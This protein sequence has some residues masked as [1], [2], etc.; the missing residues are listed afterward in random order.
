MPHD[1]DQ[2]LGDEATLQ[3]GKPAPAD[4]RSLGDRSTFGGSDGS[5]LSDLGEFA[6]LPD[7]DMEIVDLSSRYKIEKTL[8]KGG[9]GE[10]LL[11]TDTRL[12]RKVAIKRIRG[13]AGSSKAPVARFLTEAKSIAALSHNNVVQ[14]Y[15][16]GRDQDGPFLIM[17]YVSGGSLLDR[18]KQGPI[19]I[20]EAVKM[21]CQLCD[22]L[23]RAHEAG[24]IHRDIKPANILLTVDGVPKL[25]DFGLAKADSQD[26]TMTMAGAVLG[27]LDFMPPEQRQD[28]ALVDTRSDQWS[29]AATLYQMVTG[30]SPKIIRFNDV[31]ETLQ[32]VLG[33]ALEDTKDDRYQSVIDLRDALTQA[34]EIKANETAELH[35][36][37]CPHCGTKNDAT[38][39]FCRNANCGGSLEVP[40]LRCNVKIP[41]WEEVCGSCGAKQEPLI[42][43]RKNQMASMKSDAERHVEIYEFDQARRVCT[44]LEA[45]KDLRLQHLS[46]WIS[47]FTERLQT[48]E[49]RTL[50]LA[51]KR[52][53]EAKQHELAFDYPAAIKTLTRIP[54]SLQNRKLKNQSDTA[55]TY[56]AQLRRKEQQIATLESTLRE[57]IKTQQLTGMLVDVEA[58]LKLVPNHD[59]ALKIKQQLHA[60]E[61]KL[62]T[63]RDQLYEEAVRNFE[64]QN[65]EKTLAALAR[66]D[67][68]QADSAVNQLRDETNTIIRTLKSLNKQIKEKLDAKEYTELEDFVDHFLILKPDDTEKQRLKKQ[69][70]EREDVRKRNKNEGFSEAKKQFQQNDYEAALTSLGKIPRALADHEVRELRDQ[71]KDA[72]EKTT[73]LKREIEK[74]KE[75]PGATTL[76]SRLEEYLK[77]Q[78]DDEA[79]RQLLVQITEEYQR[80]QELAASALSRAHTHAH[81]FQFADALSELAAIPQE[82]RTD[83]ITVL[84]AACRRLQ[85][86]REKALYELQ[87][88]LRFHTYEKALEVTQ[89]Y[90]AASE[91]S[92]TFTEK[93]TEIENLLTE[94]LESQQSHEKESQRLAQRQATKKKTLIITGA[95]ASI[96]LVAG[97]ILWSLNKRSQQSDLLAAAIANR[98]FQQILALDPENKKGLELKKSALIQRALDNGDYATA[99]TLDP[100]NKEALSMETSSK[101]QKAL[102]EGNFATALELD[103]DSVEALSM[104]KVV[105]A[106][107]RRDY[108]TALQVEPANVEALSMKRKADIRAALARQDYDAALKLDPT[109]PEG[110]AMKK[111][112]NISQAISDGDFE[113]AL[114][115]DPDNA[116][117]LEMKSS[118]TLQ[119]A[120]ADG[121]YKT[122]LQIAPTNYQALKMKKVAEI[123]GALA[124]K[125][126]ALALK[127]DPSDAIENIP[128][129]S[130]LSLPVFYNS[131]EMQLRWIPSGNF[132]MGPKSL[133]EPTS[134]RGIEISKPFMIGVY[135]VTQL[136]YEMVMGGK[137]RDPE[138][139]QM[140]AAA[141]WAEA[142]EFC[143]KLSDLPAERAA[144]RVY[145][146]PTEAEWE[147]ACR[148]GTKMPYS[149]G[150]SAFNEATYMND[151]AWW[152][153]N[154]GGHPH[155]VG[156]KRPNPWG[157]Y[158]MH[159]NVWEWCSDWYGD[160]SKSELKDPLGTPLGKLRIMRG[161]SCN[162]KH[163]Q[164]KSAYRFAGEPLRR[165]KIIGFRVALSRS[166]N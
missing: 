15:D 73:Q 66:I 142:V 41:M 131:I 140:P 103:P 156:G 44:Q 94:C 26:H 97:G 57:R 21:A 93:D 20:D 30:K 105:L 58:L 109:N 92:G 119:Q 28:A 101:V 113:A 133:T 49:A 36:G 114:A 82:H 27:T 18:C 138:Y 135:E 96:V 132:A 7:H 34:I 69:L 88:S 83:D 141:T 124:E 134:Q 59:N 47:E 56:L 72:I 70:A 136:Q 71:I 68:T 75:T 146:L 50:E 154:S 120:L 90:H 149:F 23:A 39:K 107:A 61:K 147:Y 37:E 130:L 33:K 144:N 78:P 143:R 145:R 51:G 13:D 85:P 106:L 8:G 48:Q 25:T 99:L 112:A 79:Y 150:V 115:L 102:S 54:E 148:A 46:G 45:I 87:K 10:V 166:E 17:E 16:Y 164:C 84:E 118:D 19:A 104:K 100:A 6:D 81:N 22:G 163:E 91:S 14:V 65:Y 62:K 2:S 76:R 53:D 74:L 161:G 153:N 55:A 29:L 43:Q 77:L 80:A 110:L 117:A 125:N 98:D 129:R 116:Q 152:N 89:T 12:D 139:H 3:G 11:A 108:A 162:S 5:S 31:P 4:E 127:L 155:A 35:Q 40:C 160:Y 24:I 122:A 95:A 42:A 157:L 126:Y 60:R 9:M 128:N 1:N 63:L 64:S 67:S 32:D 137:P 38:R 159:G 111:K 165:S 86:L 123:Q 121:D 158:D 151:F 52:L